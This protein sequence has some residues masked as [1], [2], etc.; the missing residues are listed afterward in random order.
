MEYFRPADCT[1]IFHVKLFGAMPPGSGLRPHSP[2]GQLDH[3]RR[4]HEA[5]WR[6]GCAKA[7]GDDEMTV[8]LDEMTVDNIA[9]VVA[10]HEILGENG[11][12]HLAAMGVA[13]E[14]KRNAAWNTPENGGL[15][16]QQDDWP[17]TFNLCHGPGKIVAARKMPWRLRFGDLIAKAGDPE[18]LAVFRYAQ[19]MVFENVDTG[20]TQG[21]AH[22]FGA[23]GGHSG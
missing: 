15:M 22:P 8:S 11:E 21:A 12:V 4:A 19:R 17:R 10:T 7:A 1:K 13:A 18:G 16:G 2:D 14:G 3:F 23:V 5:N 9:P 20:R 6:V